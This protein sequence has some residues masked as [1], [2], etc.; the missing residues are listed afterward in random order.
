MRL[1]KC[2]LV[3]VLSASSCRYGDVKP[4]KEKL[5]VLNDSISD[6]RSYSGNAFV[7]SDFDYLRNRVF[8]IPVPELDSKQ[9]VEADVNIWGNNRLSIQMIFNHSD[10]LEMDENPD[11]ELLLKRLCNMPLD[12]IYFSRVYISYNNLREVRI[13]QLQK[14]GVETYVTQPDSCNTRMADANDSSSF[15][16][17]RIYHRR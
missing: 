3:I 11:K 17:F 14:S 1:L 13:R 4:T 6:I 16:V 2:M 8:L 7:F 10:L 15:D 5:A 9:F 12:S